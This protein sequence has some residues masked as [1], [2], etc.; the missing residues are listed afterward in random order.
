MKS[1]TNLKNLAV[2]IG[3]A[4]IV[5]ACNNTNSNISGEE[6]SQL[7]MPNILWISLEDL[8]PRIGCYGDTL[9]KTPVVDRLADEGIRFTHV[10]TSAPVCAPCRSGIITG[11][12]QSAIGTHHMR[13]SQEADGLPGPYQAVPPAY[14]KTFTEYL[15]AAGYYCTNNVKT[16]Y[17][18]A[19]PVTAWDENSPR[20]SFLNRKDKSQP[21]FAVF[22]FTDT[23]ESKCWNKPEFTNPDLVEVP[24]YYPDTRA[25]RENIAKV[26]DNIMSVDK[27]I[28]ELLKVLEESGE[29]DNTI[30]FFWTDHGDGLPRAKRWLYESGLRVPLIVK[31]PDRRYAGTTDDRLISSIDF[32]PTTL[33]LAGIEVPAHMQGRAFLGKYAEVEERDFVFAARDRFD[34]SYDMVRA[35]RTEQFR[36][37]RN[38]YPHQPYIVW[39]PYRNRMPIMQE[40]IRLNLEDSLNAVQK[41]WMAD[42]RPVE[43]LY[44]CEKDPHNIHNLAGDPAFKHI[45]QEMRVTMDNYMDE[46]NDMG[47]IPEDQMVEMFWPGGVQPETY[48]PKFIIDSSSDFERLVANETEVIPYP[49]EIKLQCPTNGASI[50]YTLETGVNPSWK[51]YTGPVPLEPGEHL[52]RAKAIRIGYKESEEVNQLFS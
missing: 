47:N 4:G 19:P 49:C 1:V 22:N 29:A 12:E 36:Y 18:F 10:F 43:E 34:L 8:S 51:L 35:I 14:V 37:I 46:I 27:K 17:Q 28:G 3:T 33:S 23:H 41:L 5:S 31:Y 20:A 25:V 9:A 7:E 21:F 45:V 24:P 11:M 32:G 2:I 48:K 50:A 40:L 39:V 6:Y 16:D 52:M 15:R 13:T 26:Y 44:D 38:Y 42:N 30:V